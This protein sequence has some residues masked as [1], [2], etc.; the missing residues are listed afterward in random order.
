MREK[1][2]TDFSSSSVFSSVFQRLIYNAMF[3]HFLDNNPI[4]SNQSWFKLGETCLNSYI[5]QLIAI[6]H[7]IFT[8]FDDGLEIRGVFFYLSKAFDKVWHEGLIYKLRL[9]VICRNLLQFMISFLDSTKQRVFFN[10]Q[11]SSW[12]FN[13][14]GVPQGL[15]IGPLLFLIYAND[16]TE[17]LQS[18]LKRFA[19]DTPLFT[20]TNDPDVT[21]KQFCEDLNKIKEW[22]FQW[23]MSFKP[24]PSKQAQEVIFTC[25]V[26]KVV[27]PPIFFNNKPVQQVSPQKDLGLILDTFLAF[28]EHI[29]I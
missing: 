7:D 6:T 8:G 5:N 23:K 17:N 9:N 18:N 25:K 1:L 14:A 20:L 2:Q 24:D 27:H 28:D 29:Y 16:L 26:K 4:S 10:G 3:K 12:G 19:D 13:T 11:C 21:D 15:I 22:A